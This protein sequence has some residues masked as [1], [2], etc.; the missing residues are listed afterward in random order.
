VNGPEDISMHIK[1]EVSSVTST[2]TIGGIQEPIIGQKVNE[3]DLRM[4]DGEASLLGGLTSDSDAKAVA[5]IPGIANIPLLGY[6]F[7][8]RSDDKEKD[9]IIIALIPHI[10][11]APAVNSDQGILAGT[12]QVVRVERKAVEQDSAPDGLAP[13]P[14]PSQPSPPQSAPGQAPTAAPLPGQPAVQPPTTP[15]TQLP[16][17]GRVL[18]LPLGVTPGQTSASGVFGSGAWITGGPNSLLPPL[19]A[20]G[21]TSQPVL[22]QRHVA[23]SAPTSSSHSV[24]VSVTPMAEA[25]PGD[26]MP[27]AEP[28]PDQTPAS[29]NP[30]SSPPRAS[31]R[32]PQQ[33]AGAMAID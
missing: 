15:P 21:Q 25:A 27:V 6:L 11:R 33:W 16:P 31:L 32:V 18:D 2:Q 1:V 9:D 26:P 14:T 28:V 24:E 19:G 30:S 29:E 5:G 10:I 4:K 7:G 13:G 23:P 8:T 22:G 12:E 20:P 3:A 17:L